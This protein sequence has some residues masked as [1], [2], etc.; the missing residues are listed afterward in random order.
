M[1][2]ITEKLRTKSRKNLDAD[3]MRLG[4]S[5]TGTSSDWSTYKSFYLITWHMAE[6]SDISGVLEAFMNTLVGDFEICEYS[7]T[8]ES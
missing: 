6:L 1:N 8:K 7:N 2:L 5:Q 3:Y 4:W